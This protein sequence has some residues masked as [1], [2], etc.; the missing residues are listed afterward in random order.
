M[1]S[2]SRNSNDT[3]LSPEQQR[4]RLLAALPAHVQD[5]LAVVRRQIE[6]EGG[7]LSGK[8]MAIDFRSF[9]PLAEAVFL[10]TAFDPIL[11]HGSGS[12]R[13]LLGLHRFRNKGGPNEISRC[14]PRISK[15]PIRG[16]KA[17]RGP[18]AEWACLDLRQA[19]DW[20]SKLG[21]RADGLGIIK[22]TPAKSRG[23]ASQYDFH[24]NLVDDVLLISRTKHMKLSA[25]LRALALILKKTVK[26]RGYAELSRADLSA[27]GL[28]LD[29]ASSALNRLRA[30]GIVG[31][32]GVG[33]VAI[34]EVI[35]AAG[36]ASLDGPMWS[37][38][39]HGPENSDL[40]EDHSKIRAKDHPVTG[41]KTTPETVQAH[42]E[43][44][45]RPP[46]N[47]RKN[48]L[49]ED[50]IIG[51][52]MP[53]SYR[54]PSSNIWKVLEHRNPSSSSAEASGPRGPNVRDDDRTFP[55][56]LVK[57]VY[58]G[59]SELRAYRSAV[60]P[61]LVLGLMRH[62]GRA[63]WARGRTGKMDSG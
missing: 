29:E 42:S 39:E 55:I 5:R 59:R 58:R 60:R 63:R 43:P 17:V 19:K 37:R 2:G 32:V 15:R 24:G 7:V 47:F 28:T 8:G 36:M 11:R 27:C 52:K 57:A 53:A 6:G 16:E 9:P 40:A 51:K 49:P 1:K 35:Q 10:M 18:L 12:V 4:A 3:G 62:A 31:K 54:S 34:W 41:R 13:L 30:K 22:I 20:L 33:R 45:K 61:N 21:N 25:E 50:S 46:L 26:S 38:E 48:Q 14:N 23:R 56:A 44:A